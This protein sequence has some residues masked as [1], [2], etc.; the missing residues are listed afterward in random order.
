[1]VIF[2]ILDISLYPLI[3]DHNVLFFFQTWPSVSFLGAFNNFATVVWCFYQ[4][5]HCRFNFINFTTGVWNPFQSCH[6]VNFPFKSLTECTLGSWRVCIYPT[7]HLRVLHVSNL[8][9]LTPKLNCKPNSAI[10]INWIIPITSS[11]RR[12]RVYKFVE[13]F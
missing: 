6:S 2:I 9:W 5:Y 1:M 3:L 11:L 7:C 8:A 12:I 13:L 10:S 4:C